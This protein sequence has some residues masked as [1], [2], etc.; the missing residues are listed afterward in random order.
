MR[1]DTS[2]AEY[3]DFGPGYD[4]AGRVAAS[5][6]SIRLT[7]EQYAPFA[8]VSEVFQFPSGGFGNTAWIDRHPRA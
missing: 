6:V 7:K 8:S 3:R 2:M 4:A 5:N 1:T